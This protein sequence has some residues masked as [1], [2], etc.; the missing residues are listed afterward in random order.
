MNLNEILKN[1]YC[2]NLGKLKNRWEISKKEF[3]KYNL[4][5]LRWE[6]FP[7]K[8]EYNIHPQFSVICSHQA[9]MMYCKLKEFEEVAV[10]E[11]DI[12]L[13]NDIGKLLPEMLSELPK[14]WQF[15]NLHSG[16][17]DQW[18]AVQNNIIQQ[19]VRQLIIGKNK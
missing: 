17:P 7:D 8:E 3:E 13:S 2:I 16:G 6:A 19:I 11:D 14:D 5:V 12:L 15:L 10:F 1:N 18:W 9:L 4:P